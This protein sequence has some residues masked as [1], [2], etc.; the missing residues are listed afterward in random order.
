MS[1]PSQTRPNDTLF[2]GRTV[3]ATFTDGHTDDVR[4]RQLPLAEYERAFVLREDEF[5][6]TALCCAQEKDWI[7]TLTPD[8]Y[9]ALRAAAEEV[10]AQGF[11]AY[12][13]RRAKREREALA[14]QLELASQMPP[15]TLKL[16]M[17]SGLKS[18]SPTSSPPSPRRPV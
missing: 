1:T 7:S 5:A 9:E 8:S 17:E 14:A 18:T 11:F 16:A 10:N 2:G 12:A 13:A 6:L 3:P 15:E 4:V